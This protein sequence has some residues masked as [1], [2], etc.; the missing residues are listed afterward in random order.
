MKKS[1][2][3]TKTGDKGTTSLIGGMRVS[4]ND[5]RIEAYGTVDEL[6]SYLGLIASL[7]RETFPDVFE[8]IIAIQH[9]LFDIGAALA[10]VPEEK[11]CPPIG[12]GEE[13]ID[14]IEKWI[15]ETDSLLPSLTNFILP[16]GNIPS[17]HAQIAR[18]IC[19]RAERQIITLSRQQPVSPN[20]LRYINRLSDYLF[21]LARYFNV[22]TGENEILWSKDC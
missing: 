1:I 2:L 9:R 21:A 16:G 18:T 12:V 10:T 13:K 11:S 4:K 6:N 20:I 15:D 7:S 19:R 17:S 8:K 3:Y 14:E 5:S 22:R